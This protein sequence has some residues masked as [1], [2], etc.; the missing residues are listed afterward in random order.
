MEKFTKYISDAGLSNNAYQYEGVEWCLSREF[1][2]KGGFLA[3]EMGL[4][5]TITMIGLFVANSLARTLIVLPPILIPQWHDQISR[6]MGV[7]PLVYHGANKKRVSFRELH[8]AR[9][10]I[11]SYDT[12]SVCKKRPELCDIHRIEWSRVVFDEAHHLRNK[13]T[14]RYNGASLLKSD[15]RWMVSGTIIQNAISDLHNLC[16]LIDGGN[17][18]FPSQPSLMRVGVAG[19][20][21][22]SAIYAE[23]VRTAV[24]LPREQGGRRGDGSPPAYILRRTK[25]SVGISI[26]DIKSHT[27]IV[28]WTDR[29][30]YQVSEELHSYLGLCAKVGDETYFPGADVPIKRLLLFMKAKQACCYPKMLNKYLEEGTQLNASSKLDFVIDVI[31]QNKDNGNGKLIFCNFNAEIAEMKSRLVLG[32]MVDVAVLNGQTTQH[33][34]ADILS[35][36][37]DAIILQI[38]TGCEGLNLQEFYSEVYFVSPHWNPAIEDQAVARCHRIGQKKEVV[39]HR[40]QMEG[41]DFS[42]NCSGSMDNYVIRVQE[43][44]RQFYK[45]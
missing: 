4:G 10:V 30:E 20:P 8:D 3:D 19:V 27:H 40:F 12:I 26:P 9:V 42:E 44:K 32:G 1:D 24:P 7:P 33:E 37:N 38:Q 35:T 21:T 45:I 17:L 11:V 41:C 5:K 25:Q 34:R 28:H 23:G 22:S 14:S 6:T 15:I 31:L 29:L 43:R 36:R 39:V 16:S 13:K 2:G 18:R